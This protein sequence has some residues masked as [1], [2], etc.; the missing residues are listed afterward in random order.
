M[1]LAVT[2]IQVFS[3]ACLHKARGSLLQ[4]V[5]AHNVV[6]GIQTHFLFANSTFSFFK[7]GVSVCL[8][9]TLQGY[10]ATKSRDDKDK[11][12]KNKE[13]LKIRSKELKS[14]M[15]VLPW[16][17]MVYTF[18]PRGDDEESLEVILANEELFRVAQSVELADNDIAGLLGYKNFQK[19][20]KNEK[21]EII[22]NQSKVFTTF[23][24]IISSHR[25]SKEPIFY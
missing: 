4:F 2:T 14:I 16:G 8:M 19:V 15:Q 25:H 17:M 13:I 23:E 20:E 21:N 24:E 3:L 7:F 18:R 12:K 6:I 22:K 10:W 9:S 5:V 1:L 11:I